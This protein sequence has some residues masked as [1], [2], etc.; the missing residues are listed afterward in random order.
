MIDNVGRPAEMPENACKGIRWKRLSD[1]AAWWVWK[2]GAVLGLPAWTL[3]LLAGCSNSSAIVEQAKVVEFPS[4]FPSGLAGRNPVASTDSPDLSTS[5]AGD[6]QI[7]LVGT[8]TGDPWVSA[9]IAQPCFSVQAEDVL[10]GLPVGS[11][12]EPL[13]DFPPSS[14]GPLLRRLPPV[15]THAAVQPV[16]SSRRAVDLPQFS[17]ESSW[18][19]L[20][21]ADAALYTGVRTSTK[22]HDLALA[23]IQHGYLLA[24]RHAYYAARQ[25]FIQVLRMVSR[26]LD[27]REG[28]TR[29]TLDLASGLRAL[30][31]AEDFVPRGTGLEADLNVSIITSAHRTPVAK[32]MPL[33]SWLPQQ[34]MDRY[35]RYAQLKLGAAVAGDPDGSIGLHALGKLQRRLGQVEPRSHP[36]AHRQAFAFQQAALLAHPFNHLAAHELGVLLADGGR[37]E[38]AQ[39]LLEQ[40]ARKEPHPVVLRNLAQVQYKLGHAE[41]AARNDRKAQQLA[42]KPGVASRRVRWVSPTEFAD[43]TDSTIFGTPVKPW[44]DSAQV[45]AG[46]AGKASGLTA[47]LKAR[48]DLPAAGAAE[49]RKVSSGLRSLLPHPTPTHNARVPAN[50]SRF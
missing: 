16:G 21:D 37:Y 7:H 33:Q 10:T 13:W 31:E 12:A 24:D 25:E 20:S 28:T 30:E 44:S 47:G 26:G 48:Q 49:G 32:D 34:I 42:A 14:A 11:P 2:L 1:V 27:A 23:K 3:L 9:E 18:E 38:E 6:C 29:R 36:L 4:R 35:F 43:A 50:R 19:N 39:S 17:L 46:H 15:E 5:P 45:T 40:V 22:I 8:M 41:Q